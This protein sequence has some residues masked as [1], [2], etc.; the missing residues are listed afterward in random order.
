MCVSKKIKKKLS[1]QLFSRNWNT[2]L[3]SVFHYFPVD[4]KE[5][6]RS[7]FLRIRKIDLYCDSDFRK[8]L[9]SHAYKNGLFL[10]NKNLDSKF[11]FFVLGKFFSLYSRE[12]NS[13]KQIEGCSL[14]QYIRIYSSFN[15]LH[16]NFLLLISVFIRPRTRVFIVG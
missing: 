8:L 6:E 11:S 14:S 10:I 12:N 7:G 3:K 9:E 13:F 4:P 2:R 15:S 1:T 5:K 16:F